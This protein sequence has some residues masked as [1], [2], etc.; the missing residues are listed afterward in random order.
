MSPELEQPTIPNEIP[1]M[2]GG[3]DF[4][5]MRRAVARQ[6]HFRRN[7]NGGSARANLRADPPAVSVR[8]AFSVE[9]VRK[10]NQL[11]AFG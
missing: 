6:H 2:S 7:G 1:K 3:S 10:L 9:I 11:A 8:V 5:G 4:V